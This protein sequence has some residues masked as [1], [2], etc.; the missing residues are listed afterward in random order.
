MNSSNH[1][2]KTYIVWTISNNLGYSFSELS[3]HPRPSQSFG[4]FS[5]SHSQPQKQ[6][7]GLIITNQEQTTL[8]KYIF[9][10]CRTWMTQKNQLKAGETSSLVALKVIM[11]DVKRNYHKIQ[12]ETDFRLIRCRWITSNRLSA[13]NRFNL[14]LFINIIMFNIMP[15]R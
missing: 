1:F 12:I 11:L 10:L 15:T 14:S 9:I 4:E 8:W 7:L 5:F 6:H 2:I 3:G 13:L